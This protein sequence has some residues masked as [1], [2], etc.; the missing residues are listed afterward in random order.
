MI[1]IR[2]ASRNELTSIQRIISDATHHMNENGIPQW[3]EV[4]P[5]KIILKD[6]IDNQQ[7]HVIEFENELTGLIVINEDQ[8]QEYKYID[9]NYDGQVLVIHRLTIHPDYQRKGLATFLMDFAEN[10]A[11]IHRYGSIRLD[12]FTLNPGAIFPYES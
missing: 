4:Y 9:W 11:G 1:T 7:M 10:V 2:P 12:A 8:P 5:N 6:D 3:D